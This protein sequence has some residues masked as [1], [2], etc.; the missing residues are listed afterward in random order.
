MVIGLAAA[1]VLCGSM[2]VHAQFS[3][4]SRQ[5]TVFGIAAVPSSDMLDPKLRSIAQQ[6]R[7][8]YPNHGFKLL[9]VETRRLDT[10]QMHVCELG[11]GFVAQTQLVTPADANGKAMLRFQ[12]N[13]NGQFAFA[14]FVTTPL[15]QLSFAEKQLPDGSL[16]VIG[17]GVR[18]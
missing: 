15:N 11:D 18:P 12:L 10:G 17:I 4:T 6:L 13:Q 8:L 14:T 3:A 16:L 1:A 7:T 2:P 9:G 5:V